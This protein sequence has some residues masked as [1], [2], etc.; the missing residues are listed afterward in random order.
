MI[1]A[2][3]IFRSGIFVSG[4][5]SRFIKI[6]IGEDALL[7]FLCCFCGFAAL[8]WPEIHLKLYHLERV[9]NVR[10]PPIEA[11]DFRSVGSLQPFLFP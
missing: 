10:D 3:P 8:K 9:I 4:T 11:R 7:R 6:R 1:Y 5:F 2:R